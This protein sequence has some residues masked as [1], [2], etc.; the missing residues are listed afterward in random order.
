[1][2]LRSVPDLTTGSFILFGII[3]IG[4]SNHLPCQLLWRQARMVL[5]LLKARMDK[6]KTATLPKSVIDKTFSAQDEEGCHF[7]AMKFMLKRPNLLWNPTNYCLLSEAVQYYSCVLKPGTIRHNSAT[8]RDS[9]ALRSCDDKYRRIKGWKWRSNSGARK[10]DRTNRSTT[11]VEI[12]MSPGT[13]IVILRRRGFSPFGFGCTA[14]TSINAPSSTQHSKLVSTA[15]RT[16]SL[17]NKEQHHELDHYAIVVYWKT[18]GGD[19]TSCNNHQVYIPSNIAMRKMVR[20]RPNLHVKQWW[21]LCRRFARLA[22]T[23]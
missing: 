14:W 19:P 20:I 16:H 1:M 2:P 7:L 21:T 17:T 11:R 22:G 4:R 18:R 23:L 13:W 8:T 15:S 9:V 10:P 12:G 3:S 6:I 5:W